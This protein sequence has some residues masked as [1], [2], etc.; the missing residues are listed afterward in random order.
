MNFDYRAYDYQPGGQQYYQAYYRVGTD[1]TAGEF[2]SRSFFEFNANSL[3]DPALN[4]AE[5][6]LAGW[7]LLG[8]RWDASLVDVTMPSL[9]P[10]QV[11]VA[12]RGAKVITN[13]GQATSAET[14][15]G[16]TPDR[17]RRG[18][19]P[20]FQRNDMLL[21]Q[22]IKMSVLR[23]LVVKSR[24]A[25]R[26]D[27]QPEQYYSYLQ[28]REIYD[29]TSR[30]EWDINSNLKSRHQL[31]LGYN[32]LFEGSRSR[33]FNSGSAWEYHSSWL[34]G[35]ADYQYKDP[36]YIGPSND[37]NGCREQQLALSSS[38][39]LIKKITLSSSYAQKWTGRPA[40]TLLPWSEY[41]RWSW[42]WQSAIPRWPVFSYRMERYEWSHH[43]GNDLLHSMQQ[44][45]NRFE[46]QYN[47]RLFLWRLG[48]QVQDARNM[49]TASNRLWHSWWLN[50]S[51]RWGAFSL[52]LDEKV[53]RYNNPYLV[54]WFQ[55]FGFD[56]RWGRLLST[57]CFLNWTQGNSVSGEWK[58][59]ALGWNFKIGTDRSSG[60]NLT[61][62]ISQ[63]F[64]FYSASMPTVRNTNWGFKLERR[65]EGW[66]QLVSMGKIDGRVYEDANGNMV[67][68]NGDKGIAGIPILI[69]GKRAAQTDRDGHYRVLGVAAGGHTVNL[70]ISQLNASMDPSIGNKRKFATAGIW[71][72]KVDFPLAPLNEVYG[73]VFYDDN[74]N[75]QKDDGEIGVP[76]VFVLFGENRRFTSSDEEGNFIFH[77]VQPGRYRVFIDPKFL[78]DT[79][80][81]TTSS[82]YQIEV[83]NQNDVRG[84]SFGI[85]KKIRP[86]RKF[87]FGTSEV[88][89]Q[90]VPAERRSLP[91]QGRVKPVTP[92]V[93]ASPEELK[94]LNA[95]GIKQYAAGD[96]QKALETWTRMLK[97]D[98]GNTEA[99]KNIERVKTKIEALKKARGQ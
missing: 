14:Y 29:L 3:Q 69:D 68:D 13:W 80:S 76:G 6:Q 31:G 90:P 91:G 93:K 10:S 86:V 34:R 33:G 37:G 82:Q 48:Y 45:S 55:N 77:N 87:I 38:A 81:V 39:L 9:S 99:K 47:W 40:D 21:S 66:G 8:G 73:E 75:G 5:L 65:F 19:F 50:G 30:A 70:D 52:S 4:R 67:Y 36:Q 95:Q 58:T 64:Y 57:S 24:F 79:I 26:R 35:A 46:A 12:L 20:T 7:K 28:A 1:Q 78:P 23:S 74:R 27:N 32:R 63:N 15:I 71:G 98:P 53:S 22:G 92:A 97:L 72:P 96:Y 61:A 11:A 83:E 94:K 2:R 59:E 44:W 85:S 89:E 43:K 51:Q 41:Q 54:Q 49:S 84:I 18:N 88:S 62:D 42:G 25:Y 60:W 56:Q 17:Q 16:R